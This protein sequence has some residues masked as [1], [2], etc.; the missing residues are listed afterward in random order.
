MKL[1][2]TTISTKA[3]LSIVGGVFVLAA[4]YYTTLNAVKTGIYEVRSEMKL[5]VERIRSE[6]KITELRIDQQ[7]NELDKMQEAIK[8]FLSEGGVA[9]RPDEPRRRK[10]N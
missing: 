8:T 10:Y 9:I 7:R 2:N 3:V 5:E 6:H 1:D 4:Q